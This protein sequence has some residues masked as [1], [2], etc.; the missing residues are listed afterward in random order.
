MKK[1]PEMFEHQKKALEF[2]KDKDYFALFME[3]GTGKSKVA[4]EKSYYLQDKGLIDSTLVIS[5]NA[6]KEQWVEEQFEEHFPMEDWNRYIWTG[7]STQRDRN[8]FQKVLSKKDKF[9]VLSF[10]IEA[11]QVSSVDVYLKTILKERFPMVIIDESTRIKNGRRKSRGKRGG[12]KRTNKILDLFEYTKYK[13]ILTGT[14]TPKSPFDLWSQFEFLKKDFF[15]MDY[16]RFTHKYGIMVKKRHPNASRD[17]FEPLDKVTYDIV[18]GQIRKIKQTPPFTMTREDIEILSIK[19]GISTRDIIL[20]SKMPEFYSHKNLRDLKERISTVTFFVKKS[21]CLDLPP[22]IYEKLYC[23]LSSEQK[24]LYNDLK[25]DMQV[26]YSGKSIT[27]LHKVV[28]YLRL[29]M[30]TGGIFPY[31]EMEF[32][33]DAEGEE[34]VD[35]NYKYTPI[36]GNCKIKVLLEDLEEVPDDTYI[37][38]WAR[39]RGEIDMITDALKDAGYSCDKYYGGSEASVITRYKRKEFRILVAN[40]IKGGEGLNLQICTLQYFFSNSHYADKRLQA[41]DRS[42]RMGQ[43]NKVTYKDIVARKTIDEKILDVLKRRENL[44]NYFRTAEMEEI[45]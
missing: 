2:I 8:Y 26:S 17:S 21:E 38:I 32:K 40:P 27:V 22:K 33:I 35:I 24:K 25:K 34:F 16:F 37:I 29:Q 28:L 9:L 5:P 20:I 4:I 6:T 36:Q 42:H 7:G 23:D 12:A 30:I 43:E 45:L 31:S 14:P 11:L 1:V 10:N 15:Y 3:Q 19:Y 41:E 44:I 39:F 13:G 18:L